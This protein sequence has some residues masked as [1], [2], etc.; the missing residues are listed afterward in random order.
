MESRTIVPVEHK[1]HRVLT[2]QQLADHYG[3]E[4][5]RISE[6]FNRIEIEVHVQ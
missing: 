1:S 4:P 2:S 3:T 6:N 5:R